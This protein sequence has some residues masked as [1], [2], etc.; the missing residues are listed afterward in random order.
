MFL[1]ILDYDSDAER[2]RIDY[3]IER[4]QHKLNITKPKGTVIVLDGKQNFIDEFVEDVCARLEQ[5][6]KKVTIHKLNSYS[7]EIEKNVKKNVYHTNEQPEF[8]EKFISYLMAKLSASYEYSNQLGKVYKL[9]S[10]KGQANLAITLQ[11]GEK[12]TD[13]TIAIDGYGDV[14]NFI[15]QKID[16]EMNTFLGGK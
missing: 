14:V 6:E 4:W 1:L 12:G 16:G 3:A 2:K 9:Y 8:L 13:I 10:K 5:S 11:E 7:P 15:S